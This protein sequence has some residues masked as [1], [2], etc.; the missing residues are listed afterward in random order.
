VKRV[1]P[2]KRARHIALRNSSAKM[3]KPYQ[4]LAN[5]NIPQL[6]TYFCQGILCQCTIC[7]C[8]YMCIC[9]CVCVYVCICVYVYM[10]MFVYVHLC[11]YMSLYAYVFMDMSSCVCLYV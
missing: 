7:I 8:L 10:N 6:V 5:H 4:T 9:V 11:T 1:K 3:I 2:Q